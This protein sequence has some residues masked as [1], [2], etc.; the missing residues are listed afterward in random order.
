[1]YQDD[2]PLWDEDKDLLNAGDTARHLAGILS[3]MTGP[4]S[5]VI[6]LNGPWGAGKTTVAQFVINHMTPQPQGSADGPKTVVFNPWL[7]SGRGSLLHDFFSQIQSALGHHELAWRRVVRDLVKYALVFAAKSELPHAGLPEESAQIWRTKESVARLLRDCGRRIVVFID[8]IDRLTPEEA[9]TVF[10]LVK[11][12]ANLPCVYYVLI[13]DREVVS[14]LIDE[15]QPTRGY[16]YLARIV[17]LAVD[18]E[19]PD[20][21][22][23]WK[24]FAGYIA[25]QAGFRAVRGELEDLW[26]EALGQLVPT[27]RHAKRVANAVQAVLKIRGGQLGGKLLASEAL[28][29]L[30]PVLYDY[31]DRN[32]GAFLG[33]DALSLPYRDLGVDSSEEASVNALLGIVQPCGPNGGIS[34]D[35]RTA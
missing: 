25:D 12:V 29:I 17:Q 32:P 20:R 13:Y 3:D 5:L 18:L 33:N 28:R 10:W 2:A 23:I 21:D 30:K 6:G 26:K 14:E 1:M 19:T 24:A 11:S 31:I 9:R 16:A 22:V 27:L 8:D 7:F 34:T 4:E 15:S 35:A